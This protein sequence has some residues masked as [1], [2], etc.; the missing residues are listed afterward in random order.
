M[1]SALRLLFLL[2]FLSHIPITLLVDSQALFGSYYPDSL[3]QVYA[4]YTA[5]YKDVLMDHDLTPSWAKGLMCCEVFFQ[6]PFFVYASF[7]ILNRKEG[8]RL[9]GIVYGA[10]TATTLVPILIYIWTFPEDSAPFPNQSD[11]LILFMFYLPYLVVPMV[12]CIYCLF[13][14]RLFKENEDEELSPISRQNATI[15]AKLY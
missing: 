14:E 2:F 9:P 5:S 10:H 3:R 12:F 1:N 7:M 11:K 15:K 13:N 6:L 8:L 4:W